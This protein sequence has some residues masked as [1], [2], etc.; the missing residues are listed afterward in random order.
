MFSGGKE[1]DRGMKWVN[2]FFKSVFLYFPI[3]D[4]V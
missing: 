3:A 4:D 2:V 1:R